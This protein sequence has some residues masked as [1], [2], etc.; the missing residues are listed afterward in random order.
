M[1]K[2]KF[3]STS[4]LLGTSI[5][6][7]HGSKNYENAPYETVRE[8]DKIIQKL[9]R[10]EYIP[11]ERSSRLNDENQFEHIRRDIANH[12]RKVNLK[13][14]NEYKNYRTYS[15]DNIQKTSRKIYLD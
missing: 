1:R 8:N 11:F 14:A 13:M 10:L 9:N 6:V 15:L 5:M 7:L 3:L 12:N 4:L 2:H